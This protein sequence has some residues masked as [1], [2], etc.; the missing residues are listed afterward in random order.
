MERYTALLSD[1][2]RAYLRSDSDVDK[3][4]RYQ[5]ASRVR[6]RIRAL[7][8]DLEFLSENRPDIHAEVAEAICEEREG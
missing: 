6:A 8:D 2:D 1:T 7:A 4:R 5:S 3:D